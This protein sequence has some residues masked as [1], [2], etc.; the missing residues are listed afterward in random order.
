MKDWPLAYAQRQNNTFF[1]LGVGDLQKSNRAGFHLLIH[2]SMVMPLMPMI[3]IRIVRVSS[4]WQAGT[5]LGLTQI[6]KH[7]RLLFFRMVM[8]MT[9]IKTI[10]MQ[11]RSGKTDFDCRHHIG[12]FYI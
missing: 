5:S 6:Q 9:C 12:S 10:F 2:G 3:P 1:G 8:V 4:G 11:S 7:I